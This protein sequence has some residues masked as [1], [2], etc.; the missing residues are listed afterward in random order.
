MSIPDNIKRVLDT[1][2][3]PSVSPEDRAVE[4]IIGS[5]AIINGIIENPAFKNAFIQTLQD[6]DF[7]GGDMFE[8]MKFAR[9]MLV[10]A[11]K[12]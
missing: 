10:E 7:K 3:D 6:P 12:D 8:D 9:D 5:I 4:G 11:L 1:L 2:G